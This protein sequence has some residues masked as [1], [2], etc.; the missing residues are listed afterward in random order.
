MSCRLKNSNFFF[1]KLVVHT[2]FMFKVAMNKKLLNYNLYFSIFLFYTLKHNNVGE[3]YRIFFICH[4]SHRS[5]N[6]CDKESYRIYSFNI[7]Y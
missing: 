5:F 2:Q 7:F 6:L 4:T 3:V 1:I